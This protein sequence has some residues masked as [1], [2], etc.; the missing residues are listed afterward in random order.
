MCYNFIVQNVLRVH[1]MKLLIH[2]IILVVYINLDVLQ[3]FMLTF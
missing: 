2:D 3:Q 1:D